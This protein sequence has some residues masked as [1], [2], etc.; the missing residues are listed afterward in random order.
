DGLDCRK[1][2]YRS[3]A[4]VEQRREVD[5]HREGS[6]AVVSEPARFEGRADGRG[7]QQPG[8][9]ERRVELCRSGQRRDQAQANGA[10][11][12]RQGAESL[13]EI[14]QSGCSERQCPL[15]FQLRQRASQ[16]PLSAGAYNSLSVNALKRNQAVYGGAL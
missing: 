9:A 15:R 16:G 7:R 11:G 3:G 8:E 1:I 6:A 4:E 10:A 14:S 5:D 2:R 12:K 13:R